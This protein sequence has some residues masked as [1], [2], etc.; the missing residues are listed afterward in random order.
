MSLF[1]V[2]HAIHLVESGMVRKSKSQQRSGSSK[3]DHKTSN[4]KIVG[5]AAPNTTVV[6]LNNIPYAIF[7][8]KDL[9]KENGKYYATAVVAANALDRGP[10][11]LNRRCF[12]KE[13]TYISEK[14]GNQQGFRYL[15]DIEECARKIVNGTIKKK[16]AKKEKL[17]I[18]QNGFRTIVKFEDKC[19]NNT[20]ATTNKKDDTSDIIPDDMHNNNNQIALKRASL[21]KALVENGVDFE[22]AVQISK[23]QYRGRVYDL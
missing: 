9:Y 3:M 4:I 21:T 8:N 1:R 7:K 15:V 11:T 14:H 20:V 12:L 13:L 6:M 22:E 18:G 23:S 10:S 16:T 5:G 17:A 2:D 19:H